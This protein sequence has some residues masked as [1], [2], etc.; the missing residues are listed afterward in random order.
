[1]ARQKIKMTFIGKSENPD[2]DAVARRFAIIVKLL[3]EMDKRSWQVGHPR[4]AWEISAAQKA[5]PFTVEIEGR[6]RVEDADEFD[7]VSVLMGGI[8]VLEISPNPEIPNGFSYDD[9]RL[10]ERLPERKKNSSV[11]IVLESTNQKGETKRIEPS[12]TMRRKIKR[13]RATA[14]SAQD[15]YIAVEGRLKLIEVSD[16]SPESA[17]FHLDLVVRETGEVIYCTFKPSDS[18][19]LGGH[20]GQSAFVEGVLTRPIGPGRPR[21]HVESF[22]L[23]PKRPLSL[24]EI[25]THNL[26][27][28][29]GMDSE[30]FV[31]SLRSKVD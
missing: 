20:I 30:E 27:I 12:E 11:R 21:M 10:L 15:E 19:V 28:P 5:S 22:R 24:E 18:E 29:S 26:R 7:V 16:D 25:H 6:K 4:Y 2:A 1:M 17:R 8:E 3:S 23:I 14:P 31:R 13:L 9:L